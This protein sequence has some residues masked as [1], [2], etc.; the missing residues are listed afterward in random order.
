MSG[1]GKSSL[2]TLITGNSLET[3]AVSE[4]ISRGRHT[5]RHVELFPTDGGGY[6]LDTPGF[7]SVEIEDIPLEMI[8]AMFSGDRGG[9]GGMQIPWLCPYR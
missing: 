4:Q 9:V 5:T 7:S 2:L 3:G 1:V 6:V 8:E